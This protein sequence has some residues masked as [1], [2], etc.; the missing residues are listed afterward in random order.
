MFKKKKLLSIVETHGNP[1]T[2]PI[3]IGRKLYTKEQLINVKSMAHFALVLLIKDGL[4]LIVLEKEDLAKVW[5]L[6]KQMYHAGGQ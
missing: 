3:L 2:F 1:I 4:I 5:D 6:L